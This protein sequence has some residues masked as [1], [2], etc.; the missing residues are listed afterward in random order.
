M[1]PTE[2]LSQNEK[3]SITKE[4]LIS[5]FQRLLLGLFKKMVIADRLAPAVNSIFDY[6]DNYSGLTTLVGAY[7]FTVQ[8]YFD[9][10]GYSD[11]AL[12][13]AKVLGYNLKE[14]FILAL[15]STSVSEFW[16]R[17]HISLITWFTNYIYYPVVYRFRTYKK[18][19][20]IIA[21]AFT[22]IISAIWH[23]IGFTFIVWALCH[24]AYLSFEVLTKR[25]R[26]GL[27]E[28]INGLFYKIMSAF[29]VFNIVCFSNIFFRAETMETAFQL[30]HNIYSCFIP[31]EW[32]SDFIAP[33][34]IGGHQL[35][36]FNFY[37]S[38]LITGIVILYERRINRIGE[39]EKLNVGY[40]VACTLL[41]ML[42]GVFDSG[43]RFIYMQF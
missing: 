19:A 36:E 16:R 29:V 14:N 17:W 37:I 5:G 8:L 28:N 34:A 21:I 39:S 6:G 30:I 1:L 10:S 27:S 12:G 22:F 23:G 38:I 2:F 9:F 4:Q 20:A 32:L 25:F 7:L 41:I 42:F 31:T 26:V 18:T 40:I 11:M 15:R 24:V 33:L 35:E 43:A 13:I 3:K